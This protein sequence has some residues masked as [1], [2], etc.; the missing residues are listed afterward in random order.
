MKTD[1]TIRQ[2][3]DFNPGELYAIVRH[4]Y[5]SSGFMSDDFDRKFPGVRQFD[6][7]YNAMLNQPGSFLLVA[8]LD[9]RPV[10]Y[11]VIEARTETRLSHTA[12]LNMGIV[13]NLRR[14]GI[15]RQLTEAT[16]QRAK[17]EGIIEI[18]YLMVRADHFGAIKLYESTGFDRLATLARDTK[19][20]GE[21]YDGLL[22]RRF[23]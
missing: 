14:K 22:M 9:N 8:M 16:L 20:D 19:F 4:V 1:I 3:H 18:I 5:L 6:F 10:G 21:Y 2:F 11:L 7:H 13:E 17:T 12:F 23:V 15:G